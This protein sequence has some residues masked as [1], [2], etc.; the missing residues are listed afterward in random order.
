MVPRGRRLCD[1]QAIILLLVL[2]GVAVT[3]AMNQANVTGQLSMAHGGWYPTVTTLGDGRMM[4]F[5][6]IN[7]NGKTKRSRL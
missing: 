4:T 5:S 2:L 7:E 1:G 6:G 3:G